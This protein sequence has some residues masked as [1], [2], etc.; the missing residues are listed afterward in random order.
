MLAK[1]LRSLGRKALIRLAVER[2]QKQHPDFQREHF[3]RIKTQVINGS[4]IIEFEMP[5][6]FIPLSSRYYYG[7]SVDLTSKDSRHYRSVANPKN[8]RS[9]SNV[10]FFQPSKETDETVLAILRNIYEDSEI[11]SLD[12]LHFPSMK[13]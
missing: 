6:M 2:I 4:V 9:K 10:S 5:I 13:R 1:E 11:Q 12:E 8:Y 7:V 3:D